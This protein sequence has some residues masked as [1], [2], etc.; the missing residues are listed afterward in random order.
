MEAAYTKATVELLRGGTSPDAVLKGLKET[1]T[2]RGY[3]R[4]Y[5]R[6]L[7]SVL[8]TLQKDAKEGTPHV[9]V[10]KEGDEATLKTKIKETLGELGADASYEVHVDKNVIGGHKVAFNNTVIDKSYKEAL[11][12]LYRNV[13]T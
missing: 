6:I 3:E 10:A 5:A 2:S 11:V 1:L 13:T 12:T 4:L 8:Q 9:T 7:E